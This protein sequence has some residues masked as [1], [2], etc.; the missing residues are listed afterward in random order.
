MFD[1]NGL[2][3]VLVGLPNLVWPAGSARLGLHLRSFGRTPSSTVEPAD[4][5]VHATRLFGLVVTFVGLSWFVSG[6]PPF[7]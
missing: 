3:L 7:P 1:P 6:R 2:L 4:W 5:Y